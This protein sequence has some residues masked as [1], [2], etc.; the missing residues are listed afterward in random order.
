MDAGARRPRTWCLTQCRGRAFSGIG[1]WLSRHGSAIGSAMAACRSHGS[2][3]THSPSRRSCGS[4]RHR[5]GRPSHHDYT[6]GSHVGFDQP[7]SFWHA[8]LSHADF[9]PF[10]QVVAEVVQFGQ[11][12]IRSAQ[13]TGFER[14]AGIASQVYSYVSGRRSL[15]RSVLPQGH[16]LG[17]PI[18][19]ECVWIFCQAPLG[20]AAGGCRTT[21]T[22]AARHP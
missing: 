15:S 11:M 9:T 17:R 7:S 3:R 8:V 14:T 13:P 18:S 12:P 4:R 20:P 6:A 10:L 16:P 19:V 22:F 1:C 2:P 21:S 5:S